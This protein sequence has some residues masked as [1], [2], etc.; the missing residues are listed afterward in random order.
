LAKLEQ[1]QERIADVLTMEGGD[2]RLAEYLGRDSM[3]R[4]LKQVRVDGST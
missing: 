2:A 1:E 4:Y 3:I